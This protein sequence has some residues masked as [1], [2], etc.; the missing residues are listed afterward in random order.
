M[1]RFKKYLQSSFI[2]LLISFLTLLFFFGC[3]KKVENE[4][5]KPNL[6]VVFPDEMRYQAMGF[7]GKEPVR[8]PSLDEFA[9]H[10]Q[11]LTQAVSNYPLCSP[12]RAMFMTGKYSHLNNVVSNCNSSR[13]TN[14]LQQ[15]DTCWSDVLKQN[16]YSLGYIGKWHLDA[17]H[18]P[19]V[20][21]YNNAPERKVKWNEWC[22]P[23]RRHG[24]DFWYAYGTYDRHLNPMYWD[25][26]ASRDEFHYVD[27]W[28]P[29]HETDKAIDY[30]KNTDNQYR[31]ENNPF[32]LVVA[33]NPP[34]TPYN[35]VPEEYLDLYKNLN[36]DSV[37]N[38]PNLNY[39]DEENREFFKKNII[40]YYA[41]ISGVD[42][43]YGRLLS[44]LEEEGIAENTI[45]LFMADHGCSLGIHGEKGK[46]NPYEESLKIPF[47]IRWPDYIAAEENDLLISV[48][49]IYP[50]LIDLVGLKEEIP[51]SVQGKSYADNLLGKSVEKPTSQP[52][53]RMN[54]K[55]PDNGARGLRT[56]QYTLSVDLSNGQQSNIRLF[57]RKNDPYQL[58]NI[59]EKEKQL[60]DS[61]FNEL[62]EKLHSI[63]DPAY[64][65]FE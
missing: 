34:H 9:N 19:Y 39:V 6:L 53:F 31:D 13:P 20:N 40:A 26:D 38:R 23:E 35:Q 4:K 59:A 57:D 47:M 25:T 55:N 1:E 45:V 28:G 60:T 8:T 48:P 22:P 15:E 41:M 56:D 43:Q 2:N 62:R 17:P 29:I 21:T 46:N 32:A 64:R 33:Y 49:D 54:Y 24:F 3:D 7:V 18:A 42:E 52:Y 10:S 16:G 44:T 12:F 37:A 11:V 27:E 58:V 14:E 5:Q 61:L 65:F 30:I 51:S 63:N 36:V 50:T